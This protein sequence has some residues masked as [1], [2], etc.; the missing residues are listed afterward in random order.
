MFFGDKSDSTGEADTADSSDSL[1]PDDNTNN[2]ALPTDTADSDIETSDDD[3]DA[4]RPNT[5]EEGSEV[6]SCTSTIC[7]SEITV[8][9]R[10]GVTLY[11]PLLKSD[12]DS[13][14]SSR[15]GTPTG[16]CYSLH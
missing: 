15:S 7:A 8:C 12:S 6:S 16:S 14:C 13:D 11:V 1:L 3:I 9:A 5:D 4:F 10:N 2:P